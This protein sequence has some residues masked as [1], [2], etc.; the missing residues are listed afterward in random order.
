MI[1][2]WKDGMEQKGLKVN[3]GKTKVMNCKAVAGRAR[4]KFPFGICRKDVGRN[5]LC[6]K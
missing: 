5:P 4:G 3:M 6:C 1:R 2:Q